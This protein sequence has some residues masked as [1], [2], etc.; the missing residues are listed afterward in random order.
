MSNK[1]RAIKLRRLDFARVLLTDT[2]PYESPVI[3]SNE[4]LYVYLTAKS[5]INP[6]ADDLCKIFVRGVK[7][8]KVDPHKKNAPWTI[9]YQYLIKK[10]VGE[11][12][13]L[14]LLHPLA[15]WRLKEL[16]ENFADLII[17]F[18]SVSA[19]SIRAPKKV[20]GSFFRKSA[21]ENIN[22][23][24]LLGSATISQKD[25]YSRFSP[26]FF[27]YR[28]YDRIYKFYNSTL[29][30][31]LEA[32]FPTHL[33]LDVSK[34]FESIYTHSIAWATKSK[35]FSKSEKQHE[36]FGSVFDQLMCFSNYGETNGIPIGP[37]S[38]RIFA[39]I[40]F[41]K[42]D[43]LALEAIA[44]KLHLKHEKQYRILRYVDD[45]F[46]FARSESEAEEI[47][48][49]YS[50]SLR[51]FNL[52]PNSAK[53]A[54]H[55]RPFSSKKSIGINGA[56]ELVERFEKKFLDRRDFDSTKRATFVKISNR[57]SLIRGFIEDVKS[58]C[59]KLTEGYGLVANFLIAHLVE[60]LK[61]VC[62]ANLVKL[63]PDALTEPSIVRDGLI[64]I[65]DA[66]FFLYKV[67]PSS[68]SSY[69]L[70]TAIIIGNE[71]CAGIGYFGDQVRG[72]I[73]QHCSD[74]VNSAK[75]QITSEAI[76]DLESINIL[77][78]S[79]VLGPNYQLSPSNLIC[80]FYD[81][82]S[83][84]DSA[85]YF[86]LVSLLWYT[87]GDDVYRAIEDQALDRIELIL[88]DISSYYL[89]ADVVCLFFDYLTCPHISLERRSDVVKTV[90]KRCALF[91]S[92]KQIL[93]FLAATESA[94]FFVDWKQSNLLNILEKKELKQAY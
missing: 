43:Q 53:K 28:G 33:S 49:L 3:F 30:Y 94:P 91:Y 89:C 81:K 76:L 55:S 4:G 40:I 8:F 19:C 54:L 68:A 39:E 24:K 75:Q 74:F 69:R 26:S 17:Y 41:Q 88:R 7:P 20:A 16:Y 5:G 44:N 9:P 13:R 57:W 72:K 47:Y 31:Q 12:R 78:A 93:D 51:G 1:R 10:D 37:E 18:C 36:S 90:L 65:F 46:I 84:L 80:F 67:S 73:A 14:A 11:Y 50:E 23:F 27:A 21:W 58:L 85:T 71:V 38:S 83:S 35:E 77:L 63:R 34:C 48:K 62:G 56:K 15:Q 2:I 52:H 6:I 64:V 70:A 25:H 87:R 59:S 66:I 82:K 61:I 60:S 45:V 29:F 79:R 86:Q 22:R 42:I 92:D 32:T